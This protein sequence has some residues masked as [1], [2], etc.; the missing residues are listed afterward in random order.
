[1]GVLTEFF[2][3]SPAELREAFTKWLEV[4][5]EPSE[6]EVTNPFTGQ[7]LII[8]EWLPKE[9]PTEKVGADESLANYRHLP[10]AE[11]KRIALLCWQSCMS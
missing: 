3:A 10:H 7:K 5:E 4:A 8:Q 9:R 11:F 6:R 2:V 1:M